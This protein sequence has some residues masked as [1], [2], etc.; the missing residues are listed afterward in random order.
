MSWLKV[1]VIEG[2]AAYGEAMCA[3]IAGS[4]DLHVDHRSQSTS[5]RAAEGPTPS[6]IPYPLRCRISSGLAAFLSKIRRRRRR[7]IPTVSGPETLDTRILRD[8]GLPPYLID[9]VVPQT[10]VEA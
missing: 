5:D 9:D 2:M 10:D 3:G 6:M 1:C 7:G 4:P 8:I